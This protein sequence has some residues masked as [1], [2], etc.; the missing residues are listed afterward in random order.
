MLRKEGRERERERDPGTRPTHPVDVLGLATGGHESNHDRLAGKATS[1]VTTAKHILAQLVPFLVQEEATMAA[2]ALNAL[3]E[4]LTAQWGEP[5]YMIDSQTQEQQ[6]SP[7]RGTEAPE[8]IPTKRSES[9][10]PANE[11]KKLVR[12]KG[13]EKNLA[14]LDPLKLVTHISIYIYII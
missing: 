6:M 11:D 3:D 10:V 12:T 7:I 13:Q 5:I 9:V 4:W 1:I 2:Q 8:T 14:P